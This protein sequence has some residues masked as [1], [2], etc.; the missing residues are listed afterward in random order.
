MR[1]MQNSGSQERYTAL[2]ML[3][4]WAIAGL[5][6]FQLGLGWYMDE[7]PEGPDRSAWFALHKSIGLTVFLLAVLRLVWRATHSPPPLPATLPRWQ[8]AMARGNHGLLYVLIFLQ[9]VTGYLSSSFSG[10]TTSFFGLPLPHWGWKEPFLNE[11][12]SD[13]HE[14]SALTLA[15]LIGLHALAAL[16][17]AMKPGD[18]LF[19]RMLPRSLFP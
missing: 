9:P 16:S 5:L 13:I 4:H 18:R 11:L 12:F 8:R 7:L 15:V 3:M 19:R 2:A 1:H 6:F 10:Y 17:H 14:A